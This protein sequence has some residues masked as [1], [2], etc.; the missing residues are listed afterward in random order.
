MFGTLMW[1]AIRNRFKPAVHK[2][3]VLIATL[4]ILDAAYDRWPVP[5]SWWDDRVT[6]LICTYPLLLLLMAYDKWSTG[7]VQR[8]T[9]WATAFLVVVQQGRDPFG[10]TVLWQNFAAWVYAHSHAWWIFR[11]TV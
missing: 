5:V 8:V 4:S 11:R 7:R 6:P 9:L 3:L 2:R 10:H 1:F